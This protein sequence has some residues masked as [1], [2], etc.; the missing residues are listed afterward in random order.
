IWKRICRFLASSTGWGDFFVA[1]VTFCKIGAETARALV[2]LSFCP[3]MILSFL[4]CRFAALCLCVEPRIVIRL[5]PN[6]D[7]RLT[8]SIQ[9]IPL[10]LRRFHCRALEHFDT[11]AVYRDTCCVRT[12]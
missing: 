3:A 6:F 2:L 12:A 5:S 9:C 10:P 8:L 4:D 11:S 7:N 1:F